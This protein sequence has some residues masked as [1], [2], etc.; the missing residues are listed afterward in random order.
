MEEKTQSPPATNR[1]CPFSFIQT[2]TVGSGLTPD[3]LTPSR[4]E[5]SRAARIAPVY[6]RWGLSPRPENGGEHRIP[7]LILSRKRTASLVSEWYAQQR[8]WENV[9]AL[10]LKR[11]GALWRRV[12]WVAHSGFAMGHEVLGMVCLMMNAAPC[13]S[14]SPGCDTRLSTKSQ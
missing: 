9:K 8:A 2:V 3:L 4:E 5:R 14:L 13:V 12:L 1:R 7:P 10:P 6:R 11:A